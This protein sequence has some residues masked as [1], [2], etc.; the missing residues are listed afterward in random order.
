M[1]IDAVTI[2]P[3]AYGRDLRCRRREMSQGVYG[4]FIRYHAPIIA[5]DQL[6]DTIKGN[7][8][9]AQSIHR[10]VPWVNTSEDVRKLI[11]VYLVQT[12]TKRVLRYNYVGD[13][14]QPARISEIATLVGNNAV[15]DPWME[16]LFSRVHFYPNPPTG[17]QDVMITGTDRDGRSPIGSYSYMI[18]E[19]SADL[20]PTLIRCERYLAGS[21]KRG[22]EV[23]PVFSVRSLL[24]SQQFLQAAAS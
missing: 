22:A 24:E 20:P 18:G 16:W 7:E 9:L 12:I 13:G 21:F 10:F 6:F 11:D 3:G 8:E 4:N 5:Y 19:F 17:I 15:T 2:E 23:W 14:R 1:T